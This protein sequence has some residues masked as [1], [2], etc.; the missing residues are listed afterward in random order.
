[1]LQQKVRELFWQVYTF[2]TSSRLSVHS[3]DLSQSTRCVPNPSCTTFDQMKIWRVLSFSPSCSALLL[4]RC[5]K[6]SRP[7]ENRSEIGAEYILNKVTPAPKQQMRPALVTHCVS[8][9]KP[10]IGGKAIR[11]STER[12]PSKNAWS[13]M[14]FFGV[15]CTLSGQELKSEEQKTSFN[16]APKLLAVSWHLRSRHTTHSKAFLKFTLSAFLSHKTISQTIFFFGRISSYFDASR[17]FVLGFLTKSWLNFFKRLGVCLRNAIS[18]CR[19]KPS[20]IWGQH[21]FPRLDIQKQ[22]LKTCGLPKDI[23]VEAI[24]PKR[25]SEF[26]PN[27]QNLFQRTTVF[28]I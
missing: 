19:L 27:F 24:L 7:S 23:S 3:R 6:H 15:F 17:H 26:R 28:D 10:K 9:L 11:C 4:A 21:P 1:M 20:H 13:S 18:A 14:K 8:G 2:C 12:L 25:S 22:N 5:F 16:A